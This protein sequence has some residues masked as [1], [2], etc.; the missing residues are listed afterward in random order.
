MTNEVMVEVRDL[1]IR[2]PVYGVDQRSLKK[3]L[4]KIAIGGVLG[5]RGQA[6]GSNTVAALS[7]VNLSLRPGDRLALVGPNGA[8]KTTLLRVIA[9]VYAPDEGTVETVGKIAGLLD[10]SLGLQPTATGMEN[11]YLRGLV[12]GLSKAEIQAKVADIGSFSGLGAFLGLPLKTY[13]SGMMARLAFA[14][15][16]SV[17]ADILLMDEWI[18]VG[19]ADFRDQAQQRLTRMIEQSHIMVLASHEVSLI[20]SLCNKFMHLEHGTASPVLPVEQIDE[21]MA[22]RAAERAAAAA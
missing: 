19:D 12:A 18:A 13:S 4:A 10:L 5:G 14:V 7:H 2:F 21:F 22:A 11:I 6:G 20:K 15:A 9:G 8:G 1:A 17:D 3:Q 16:T